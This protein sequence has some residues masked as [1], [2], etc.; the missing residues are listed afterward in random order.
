MTIR[1]THMLATVLL[2]VF[3]MSSAGAEE[4][5][6]SQRVDPV[7]TEA[8]TAL[9]AKNY[10]AVVDLYA[11]HVSGDG[12][13]AL[14]HYRYAIAAKNLGLYPEADNSFKKAISIAPLGDFATDPARLTA[15][16]EQIA[17]G[18]ST[19]G[20]CDVSAPDAPAPE[21]PKDSTTS[22]EPAQLVIAPTGVVGREDSELV[23]PP[24]TLLVAPPVATNEK[25]GETVIDAKN[26]V[27][28]SIAIVASTIVAIP[29]AVA[30]FKLMRRRRQKCDTPGDLVF[31]ELNALGAQ[32]T[33]VIS[34]IESSCL[35][36]ELLS[37]LVEVERLVARETGRLNYRKTGR[38]DTLTPEDSTRLAAFLELQ[39]E[40]ADARHTT[41]TQVE[42]AFRSAQWSQVFNRSSKGEHANV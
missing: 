36:S 28:L 2:A 35:H 42:A 16:Q 11:P 37:H 8:R 26:I 32:L 9:A 30:F 10:R 24:K 34:Y 22:S 33:I 20:G 27:Q 5:L 13:T 38:A 12:L 29:L 40:P 19:Q 23:P 14:A 15:L 4:S 39:S 31:T 21:Q 18:C 7:E 25:V 3:V 17:E 1:P 41:P 6:A